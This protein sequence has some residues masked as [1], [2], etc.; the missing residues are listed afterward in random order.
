[1]YIHGVTNP[2]RMTDFEGFLMVISAFLLYFLLGSLAMWF[3]MLRLRQRRQR[4]ERQKLYDAAQE[5]AA[6]DANTDSEDNNGVEK[7][8]TGS[9][10]PQGREKEHVDVVVEED[11]RGNVEE[12]VIVSTDGMMDSTSTPGTFSTGPARQGVGPVGCEGVIDLEKGGARI[13][14]ASSLPVP[15]QGG[16]AASGPEFDLEQCLIRGVSV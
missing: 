10:E 4:R 15:V 13:W 6:A 1:M 14:N 8:A 5:A 9:T 12:A 3:A 2:S 7:D 16:R 11:G